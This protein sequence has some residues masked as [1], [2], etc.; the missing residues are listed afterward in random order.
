MALF[1]T[2]EGLDGSGKSTQLAEA[3]VWLA[4]QGVDLVVTQEPGGT[5]FGER[6]RELFLGG[7]GPSDGVVEALLVFAS[8]RQNLLQLIEP[9]LEAGRTVLCD[10]FTDS[11]LAYQGA[12]RGLPAE[13]LAALD[14]IATGGRK[15]DLTLL[16]DVDPE[17]AR[18]RR[19]VGE[20]DRLDAETLAF[21]ERVRRGYLE[22]A[23]RE[24]ER[25]RVLDAAA[26]STAVA[27]EVRHLLALSLGL[28][29]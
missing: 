1:I 12:G 25:F 23:R 6:L 17:T 8:R 22:M 9:A 26:G 19:G 7:D 13:S 28:S 27:A 21:Q 20:R 29:G 11:T 24:P 3:A 18:S 10:R 5:P 16:F 4:R 2:F 14:R 15:P